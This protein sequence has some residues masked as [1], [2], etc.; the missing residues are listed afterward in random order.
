MSQYL[1]TSV[2]MLSVLLANDTDL[3]DEQ[4]QKASSP[5]AVTFLGIVTD[6]SDVQ[7]MN[8]MSPITLRFALNLILLIV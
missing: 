6:V 1:N 4:P 7:P 5:T 3:S 2:P 8:A